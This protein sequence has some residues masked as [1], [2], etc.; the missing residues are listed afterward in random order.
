MV[1]VPG[2]DSGKNG[3]HFAG[4]VI[5]ACDSVNFC[6]IKIRKVLTS[7]QELLKRS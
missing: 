7:G 2:E 1:L 3:D 6:S 4:E 5:H